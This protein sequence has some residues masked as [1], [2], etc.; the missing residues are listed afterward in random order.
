L[1]L[2]SRDRAGPGPRP[3]FFLYPE[4]K[5]RHFLTFLGFSWAWVF[6][7]LLAQDRVQVKKSNSRVQEQ[8]QAFQKSYLYCPYM[9][10]KQLPK[11]PEFSKNF[12]KQVWEFPRINK[13]PISGTCN[14]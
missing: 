8:V 14:S 7:E 6:S 4:S 10:V 5:S 13:S 12:G 3:G 9:Y 11:I 2:S 1:Y